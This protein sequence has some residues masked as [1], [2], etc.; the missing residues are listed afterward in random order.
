MPAMLSKAPD[1]QI[2]LL[3][4]GQQQLLLRRDPLSPYG[5]QSESSSNPLRQHQMDRLTLEFVALRSEW[6]V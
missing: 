3:S 5:K 1:P 6:T 2:L 4:D